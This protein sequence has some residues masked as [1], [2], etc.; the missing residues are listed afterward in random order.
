MSRARDWQNSLS[1]PNAQL[2]WID[3]WA[4]MSMARRAYGAYHNRT[5]YN[6]NYFYDALYDP[7]DQINASTKDDQMDAICSAAKAQGIVVF[8]IGFEVTDHSAD[9]MRDCASTPNH[10]YR[11]E[12]LDIEYAFASI[13]NQINQLKLTQ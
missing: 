10:F 13:A 9:V 7:R 3:A 12:G 6:S 2:S 5:P 8:S 1:S 4:N 11:V